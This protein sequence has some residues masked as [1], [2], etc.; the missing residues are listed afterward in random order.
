MINNIHNCPTNRLVTARIK[1]GYQTLKRLLWRLR[2]H[3]PDMTR[4]L[5]ETINCSERPGYMVHRF[6]YRVA[7]SGETYKVH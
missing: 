7:G 4:R 5:Q 2:C 3:S 1:T 6:E